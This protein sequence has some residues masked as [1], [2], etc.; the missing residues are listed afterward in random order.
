MKFFR[1]AKQIRYSEFS[2]SRQWFG[3]I[4][5]WKDIQT[6]SV[7][8]IIELNWIQETCIQQVRWLYYNS[9]RG[10]RIRP[11]DIWSL[12]VLTWKDS[13]YD[14]LQMTWGLFIWCSGDYEHVYWD[15][16]YDR[17]GTEFDLIA[18]VEYNFT[19]NTYFNTYS[20]SLLFTGGKALWY[21][22]DGQGGIWTVN[23]MW[24][25]SY[26]LLLSDL[27]SVIQALLRDILFQ[28]LISDFS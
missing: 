6:L 8:E 15:I 26:L 7:P 13:S 9:Q 18:G 28:M 17:S 5:L 27:P 20:G 11:L 16:T 4:F 3:G 14:F 19:G 25:Q 1:Y 24:P 23:G 2:G 22:Y 10:L 12:G 21:I